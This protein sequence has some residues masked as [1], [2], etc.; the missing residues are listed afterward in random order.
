MTGVASALAYQLL[1]HQRISLRHAELSISSSQLRESALSIE[2]LAIQ[3]LSIADL[4]TF[5]DTQDTMNRVIDRQQQIFPDLTFHLRMVDL[6][7][8]FNVNALPGPNRDLA[9]PVFQRLCDFLEIDSRTPGLWLDWMDS[10]QLAVQ[11]GAEDNHYLLQKPAF[12]TPNRFVADLSEFLIP[13]PMPW[14]DFGRLEPHINAL[15][16]DAL[17]LNINTVTYP[18]LMAFDPTRSHQNQIE[19]VLSN[20]REFDT[21]ADAVS[22]LPFLD[23]YQKLFTPQSQFARFEISVTDNIS[24]IDLE[25]SVII[26]HQERLVLE[27]FKRNFG[28]RYEWGTRRDE[29]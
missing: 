9:F 11:N 29:V 21:V 16:T 18:I 8:K 4:K 19:K 23:P 12:R 27:V 28:V 6:G 14:E 7:S 5:Q 26:H 20:P 15:P 13:T 1:H 25:S 17:A 2:A 22:E 3:V 24:R 10:D